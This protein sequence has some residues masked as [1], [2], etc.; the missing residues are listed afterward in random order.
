MTGKSRRT[1]S[2]ERSV[3]EL[4]IALGLLVVSGLLVGFHVWCFYSAV[5]TGRFFPVA[6]ELEVEAVKEGIPFDVFWILAVVVFSAECFYSARK[7]VSASHVSTPRALFLQS[8]AYVPCLALLPEVL[9]Y[10]YVKR[11][12]PYASVFVFPLVMG[13]VVALRR[14]WLPQ[15]ATKEE[16]P[17]T[18][19]RR[20]FAVLLLMMCAYVL[21]FSWLTIRRY[22]GLRIGYSDAGLFWEIVRHSS[23]GRLFFSNHYLFAPPRVVH[24]TFLALHVQPIL[25]LL[26]PFY[27]LNSGLETLIVVQ[28]V[29]LASGALAVYLLASD[30]LANEKLALLLAGVYLL[31]PPLE[32]LH[33]NYYEGFHPV[34]LA[35]PFLLFAFLFLRR[36]KTWAF[37]VFCLLALFCKENVGLVVFTLGI[38]AFFFLKR[39]R[40]GAVTAAAGILWTVVCA[41]LVIPYFRGQAY[42]FWQDLYPH[43]GD[44][45]VHPW[46]LL[47]L[48]FNSRKV[49]FL[50][51]LLTPLAFLALLSPSTLMLAI[52]PLGISLLVENQDPTEGSRWAYFSTL[53]HNHSLIIPGVFISAVMGARRIVCWG[54][55]ARPRLAKWKLPARLD[56]AA[57][58]RAVAG[59]LL[60]TALLCN[61]FLGALP[62]SISFL[63]ELVATPV[64]AELVPLLR[65][66]IPPDATLEATD[67]MA[68]HF[69]DRKKMRV[70]PAGKVPEAEYV[71]LD[72]DDQWAQLDLSGKSRKSLA[73][74]V[75]SLER[76]SGYDM[77]YSCERIFLFKRAPAVGSDEP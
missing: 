73:R 10:S 32:N 2:G 61:F 45:L 25:L 5:C 24:Q 47:G 69:L 44:Q 18:G 23:E 1:T 59:L 26:V 68:N 8:L 16:K 6:Q 12:L 56:P 71:L 14:L 31:Y 77:L 42:P 55:G 13:L 37:A 70:L 20:Y 35:V 52:F 48:V 67:F 34:S 53:F 41:Q 57:L 29:V 50:L 30:V 54:Q 64:K 49:I 75:S 38:Y 15:E 36:G 62:V 4:A 33:F 66:M 17:S 60:V 58:G 22:H 51:E 63:P 72:L 3:P 46:K 76:G 7:L 40:L 39:R 65:E 9:Y 43:L 19:A 28:A 11:G 74:L 27:W 21:Y